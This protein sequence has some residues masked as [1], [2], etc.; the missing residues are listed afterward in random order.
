MSVYTAGRALSLHVDDTGLGNQWRN[1][2]RELLHQFITVDMYV[3]I[4]SPNINARTAR[5]TCK[6]GK[7]ATQRETNNYCQI[8]AAVI[9]LKRRPISNVSATS[10][11]LTTE[12]SP[13]PCLNRPPSAPIRATTDV[14]YI[15]RRVSRPSRSQCTPKSNRSSPW[16][17]RSTYPIFFSNSGW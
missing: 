12:L 17:I 7:Q 9:C 8:I 1:I 2:A 4:Y 13:Q 3:Q 16:S 5:T 10:D 6:S 15:P 11:R 14:A